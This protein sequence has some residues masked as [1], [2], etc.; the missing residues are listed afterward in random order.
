MSQELALVTDNRNNVGIEANRNLK[1]GTGD[2]HHI[3]QP[4]YES[5]RECKNFKCVIRESSADGQ[6]EDF[7]S[8][9]IW[10]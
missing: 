3:Q 5:T 7:H 2:N 9:M 6:K 4:A 10:T 8:S 1:N